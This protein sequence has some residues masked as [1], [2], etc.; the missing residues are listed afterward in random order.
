MLDRWG[1]GPILWEGTTVQQATRHYKRQRATEQYPDAIIREKR[2]QLAKEIEKEWKKLEYEREVARPAY[3]SR[4]TL[5]RVEAKEHALVT[6]KEA[7]KRGDIETAQ[8]AL[9]IAK[10]ISHVPSEKVHEVYESVRRARESITRSYE[11]ARHYVS[12]AH[13]I[14]KR[15]VEKPSAQHVPRERPSAFFVVQ[16][17][18]SREKLERELELIERIDPWARRILEYKTGLLS[19]IKSL[20]ERAKSAG[21]EDIAQT[22]TKL[23]NM[24]SLYP[25]DYVYNRSKLFESV[26]QYYKTYLNVATSS[27]FKR[28]YSGPEGEIYFNPSTGEVYV[29]G[30]IPKELVASHVAF[31]KYKGFR[32]IAH[33][34]PGGGYILTDVGGN[35]V[36]VDRV[37][38]ELGIKSIRT[39]NMTP[40][41]LSQRIE[42]AYQTI[43]QSVKEIRKTAQKL[44][45]ILSGKNV[46]EQV[47]AQA[48]LFLQT[49]GIYLDKETR[50]KLRELVEKWEK[51]FGE[52]EK[53][54][55]ET[56]E[57]WLGWTRAVENVPVIGQPLA[58][59][60]RWLTAGVMGF[61]YG[62]SAAL[63][64]IPVVGKWVKSIAP[65][66]RL[67][68]EKL[69]EVLEKEFGAAGPFTVGAEVG[70]GLV[71]WVGDIEKLFG[72][73]VERTEALREAAAKYLGGATALGIEVASSIL[74][75]LLSGG[76]VAAARAAAFASARGAYRLA[77][78][79]L[80][81]ARALGR[82]AEVTSLLYPETHLL[83]GVERAARLIP[84]AL[85]T[86]I[87]IEKTETP[88]VTI[89]KVSEEGAEKTV[90]I[91]EGVKP[92]EL[93]VPESVKPFIETVKEV[94]EGTK[95]VFKPGVK[96]EES[97]GRLHVSV[98]SEEVPEG[99][100]KVG[101]I[102]LPRRP[103]TVKVEETPEGYKITVE[104]KAVS[105]EKI[106]I[107]GLGKRLLTV[108]GEAGV[109]EIRVPPGW[110]PSKVSETEIVLRPELKV[111]ERLR[112]F[113]ERVEE[114]VMPRVTV[115]RIPAKLEVKEVTP[116]EY[117][118]VIKYREIPLRSGAVGREIELP[119]FYVVRDERGL[120]HFIPAHPYARRVRGRFY[121][122]LPRGRAEII[123]VI[124][125]T[126]EGLKLVPG[127]AAK[128]A[129]EYVSNLVT[130]VAAATTKMPGGPVSSEILHLIELARAPQRLERVIRFIAEKLAV[131]KG[132]KLDK[133]TEELL[134]RALGEQYVRGV[135]TPTSI[136]VR[137]R[138]GL[139]EAELVKTPAETAGRV[140]I[141]V[142][143]EV[144]GETGERVAVP[145]TVE[146]VKVGE[147]VLPIHRTGVS[148]DILKTLTETLEDILKIET[149][150]LGEVTIEVG[151]KR[152][153]ELK[154]VLE[155][156][157]E[158]V[159]PETTRQEAAIQVRDFVV[160]A[161]ENLIAKLRQYV[162]KH[163]LTGQELDKFLEEVAEAIV[164]RVAARLNI[165]EPS[166][167][168]VLKTA[169]QRY[170]KFT[171][172]SGRAGRLRT[173]EEITT[174]LSRIAV[175]MRE[176]RAV[177]MLRRFVELP[178][179]RPEA[180]P[181]ELREAGRETGQV[182]LLEKKA[183]V[184]PEKTW[185]E[186]LIERLRAAG[187]SEE[188]EK[189]IDEVVKKVVEKVW[190]ELSEK[191]PS[192]KMLKLL[193]GKLPEDVIRE[194]LEEVENILRKYLR[195]LLRSGRGKYRTAEEIEAW[196][197]YLIIRSSLR[198]LRSALPRLAVRTRLRLEDI[199]RDWLSMT[200][201]DILAT[202]GSLYDVWRFLWNIGLGEVL[203]K[204][205]RLGTREEFERALSYWIRSVLG[206]YGEEEYRIRM[207][208]WVPSTTE[209]QTPT[210]GEVTVPE[211]TEEITP[212]SETET[213]TPSSGQT[214]A[215]S[216]P[217]TV[218]V[219][220]GIPPR[221]P[222]PRLEVPPPPRWLPSFIS[223]VTSETG[224]VLLGLEQREV[225][226]L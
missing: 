137:A 100:T 111:P 222:P 177:Q 181:E 118:F 45:Q 154:P 119:L 56:A 40:T 35:T 26:L 196:V 59:G 172:S 13:K 168:N 6:A 120:V 157:R 86:T 165:T 34:L 29:F 163:K 27:S 176:Q 215:P 7:L 52:A 42:S 205:V 11:E 83:R 96:V 140:R 128:E 113:A 95:I 106:K 145:E 203:V 89:K 175:K 88:K 210:T 187:I 169:V 162:M 66:T 179:A 110:R 2:K 82:A 139:S 194:V 61:L 202:G 180:R 74:P 166:I 142:V 214:P 225:I 54:A 91:V 186:E 85:R 39:F 53:W 23:Y 125:L 167:R 44:I 151:G 18:V 129:E 46:S 114:I 144:A 132:I 155:I 60:L 191:I 122:P 141:T 178:A 41:D 1:H 200:I 10:N 224:G 116:G 33:P 184:K 16:E 3:V 201:R 115:E 72:A 124:T 126:P 158:A 198:R 160:R 135:V 109:V 9:E 20:I 104:G 81:T 5:E 48:K 68:I 57:W 173:L 105:T 130:E 159:R 193:A 103:P 123:G 101:E 170:L 15:T 195:E 221:A 79:L 90:V 47:V 216:P 92:S 37:L 70:L 185:L 143:K 43:T 25:A 64:G 67:H 189:I 50:K 63:A 31:Y 97:G 213:T 138:R 146:L 8:K 211:T 32:Y 99:V 19:D 204:I 199:V 30:N 136:Y 174:W 183:E 112:K 182:L 209:T 156:R 127:W 219:T 65:G 14:V 121:V 55:K 77:S 212:P 220:R 206:R 117:E 22:L 207:T 131:A 58:Q 87:K 36:D 147:E 164:D 93:K 133:L 76:A 62:A 98:P 197:G 150:R 84:R 226:V 108:T 17:T 49:A 38:R 102:E 94:K 134:R 73:K 24:I 4:E 51:K 208:G 152:V 71:G 161:D 218:A 171:I 188:A 78:L 107:R 21:R 28:V 223:Y 75:T 153:A 12:T 69:T 217:L 148:L 80:R 192:L 190:S 149:S